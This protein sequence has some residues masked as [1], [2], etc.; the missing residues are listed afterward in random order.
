MSKGWKYGV[1]LGIVIVLL[2][3]ANLLIGSVT[4]P[5]SD[6]FRILMGNEGEKASWSFIVWESRL[7]QA[8]T[9]LLCVAAHQKSSLEKS[10]GR[11]VYFG[12]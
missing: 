4:I 10:V 11:P 6:V 3:V 7:P 9:A 2:F 12:H 1:G 8:L 5:V